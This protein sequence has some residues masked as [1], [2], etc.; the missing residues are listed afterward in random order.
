MHVTLTYYFQRQFKKL[1]RSLKE[2]AFEKIELFKLDPTHGQLK[3][4]KLSGRLRDR[5]SFS[6]N[7]KIRIIYTYVSETEVALLAIGDHDVYK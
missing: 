3:A 6:V 5:Y 1:E 2:E 7:Y 4:H